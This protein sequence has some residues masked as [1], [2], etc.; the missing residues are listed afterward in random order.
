M[1]AHSIM[2]FLVCV[3]CAYSYKQRG[4]GVQNLRIRATCEQH[5]RSILFLLHKI[6]LNILSYGQ[7]A[8]SLN[9]SLIGFTSYLYCGS[10]VVI[11]GPPLHA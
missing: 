3:A 8:P 11:L 5:S 1:Q 10:D 9:I 2:A 4:E 7:G 6:I